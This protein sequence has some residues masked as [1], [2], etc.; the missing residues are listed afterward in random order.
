MKVVT[1]KIGGRRGF[2]SMTMQY[3]GF[4]FELKEDERLVLDLYGNENAYQDDLTNKNTWGQWFVQEDW[5][6]EEV[7]REVG[8]IHHGCSLGAWFLHAHRRSLHPVM[9][10]HLVVRDHILEKIKAFKAT[11]FK[12][13]KVLGVH[14]RGNEI[15]HDNTR[16]KLS[17]NYYKHKID[18]YLEKEKFDKIL[19]CSDQIHTINKLK[20][21]YGDKI[22]TYP[23]LPYTSNGS[24]DFVHNKSM[25]NEG[26]IR[27]E[28]VLIES[29]LLAET[30]FLLKPMS[31]MTNFSLIYN[32]ELE[33]CDIDL[34]FYSIKNYTSGMPPFSDHKCK[35][36]DNFDAFYKEIKTFEDTLPSIQAIDRVD[37]IQ[38]YL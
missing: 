12:D 6:E 33:Y 29:I 11:Y 31:G 23:S 3:L 34:P 25:P 35:Y 36:E 19:V 8:S 37:F 21:I 5:T 16:P 30:A 17:F 1:T 27:G 28:D 4:T 15:F 24:H 2:H 32:P 20:S 13:S 9:K 7:V 22:I 26:Y 18:L 14:I 38:S 10:K